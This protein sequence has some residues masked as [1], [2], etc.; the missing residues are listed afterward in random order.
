PSTK[1][2]LA[3]ATEAVDSLSKRLD[4]AETKSVRSS[5]REI[6][7]I[8]GDTVVKAPYRAAL[9][10]QSKLLCMLA[11]KDKLDQPEKRQLANLAHDLKVKVEFLKEHQRD[12]PT[13]AVTVH[14][15]DGSTEKKPYNVYYVPAYFE[16]KPEHYAVIPQPSSPTSTK[17]VAGFWV[18]W[19][20]PT[21]SNK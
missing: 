16:D 9:M 12:E 10:E 18:M 6:D 20:T 8:T 4:G 19:T 21:T 2:L 3:T 7:L 5:L 15:L 17:L 11:K 13:V 14:T 1:E